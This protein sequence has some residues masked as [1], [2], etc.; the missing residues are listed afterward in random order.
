MVALAY[1]GGAGTTGGSVQGGGAMAIG[2]R[3]GMSDVSWHPDNVGHLYCHLVPPLI[4]LYRL[5]D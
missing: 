4:I 5:P 2:G 3:R 1:S